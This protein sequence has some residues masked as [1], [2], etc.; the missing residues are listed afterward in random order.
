MTNVEIKALRAKLEM[1][2]EKLSRGLGI[3]LRTYQDWEAGLWNPNPAALALLAH[4]D[5]CSIL[6]REVLKK[7]KD[8]R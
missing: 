5:Q 3:P 8:P 7:S 4:L 2:Q 6:Q 1:S